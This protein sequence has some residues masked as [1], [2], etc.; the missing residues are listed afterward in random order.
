[1]K[2]YLVVAGI[3]AI[4]VVAVCLPFYFVVGANSS[5]S[6]SAGDWADFA[7][8]VG[9]LLGPALAFVSILLVLYTISQRDLESRKRDQLTNV[10]KAEEAVSHWLRRSLPATQ[11]SSRE[12]GDVVWGLVKSADTDDSHL[13]RANERLLELVCHYSET[14]ALYGENIDHHFIYRF[15]YKQADK[16]ISYLE[17]NASTLQGMAGPSLAHCRQLLS[18]RDDA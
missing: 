16:L 11:G 1:M 7:T 15:H 18:P 14:I 6:D 9:N 3:A 12:F 8:Y 17:A 10:E 2:P 4:V 13:R 5:L